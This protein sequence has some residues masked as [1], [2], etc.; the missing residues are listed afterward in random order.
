M[1]E[2][3]SKRGQ[4]GPI[5]YFSE[6]E[7]KEAIRRSKTEYM[8]N[9]EW[10]CYVCPLHNYKLAGKWYHLRTEKHKKRTAVSSLIKKKLNDM[11]RFQFQARINNIDYLG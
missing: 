1:E 9:K 3:K 5:K 11:R 10:Y 8:A 4:H 7:R 2:T 6:E